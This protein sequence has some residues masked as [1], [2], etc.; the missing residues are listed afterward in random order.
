MSLKTTEPVPLLLALPGSEGLAAAIAA[1]CG[2]EAASVATHRF[3]DGESLV[4]LE[5]PVQGRHVVLVAHL[6]EPDAKL[7]PLLFAADTARELGATRVTL[8]APY[9]PYMRQ[10]MRFRA[11]EAV[12]SH[13]FAAVVSAHVDALLTIDPHLHRIASLDAIYPIDARALRAA[14]AMADWLRREVPLPLLVGPDS[15]S[16]QWVESVASRIGAPFTV[17]DKQR[18]G[19]HDVAVAFREVPDWR[20]RTPVLLD[21]IVSTGRT[22]AAAARALIEAGAAAPICVGVHA[23][24]NSDAEDALRA[25]GVTRLVTCDTVPHPTN[26]IPMAPLLAAALAS[27]S[28][29]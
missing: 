11:G 2:G 25:A 10:D 21:D 20:G 4:R 17:L 19:D 22:L 24:C 12:T 16:A 3:P 28:P 26:A 13:T 7:L 9:L 23:L 6:H 29:E 18:F 27:R 8:V 5:A 14:P 1:G 15:E